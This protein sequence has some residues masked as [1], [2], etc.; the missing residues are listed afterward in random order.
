MVY[1]LGGRG[2]RA[3]AAFVGLPVWH[4]GDGCTLYLAVYHVIEQY[5]DNTY[6]VDEGKH[7]PQYTRDVVAA[8]T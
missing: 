7:L 2:K 6:V 1:E 8:T 5:T 3:V 4:F